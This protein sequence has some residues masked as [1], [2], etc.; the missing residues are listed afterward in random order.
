MK[1]L[2]NIHINVQFSHLGGFLLSFFL[3][4]ERSCK[5]SVS[6]KT[7][8]DAY[9][10]SCVQRPPSS[11]KHAALRCCVMFGALLF[12]LIVLFPLCCYHCC[13]A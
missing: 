7:V 3:Y 4:E 5:G 13:R 9:I 11:H 8:N 2:S 10:H 12:F 6:M 1:L